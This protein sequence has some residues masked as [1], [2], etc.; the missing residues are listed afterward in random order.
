LRNIGELCRDSSVFHSSTGRPLSPSRRMMSKMM[1]LYSCLQMGKSREEAERLGL[2]LG[3]LE[4]FILMPR[5][6]EG[7]YPSGSIC[8]DCLVDKG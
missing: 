4:V 3:I 5:R 1:V 6:S 8:K 2:G 7:R